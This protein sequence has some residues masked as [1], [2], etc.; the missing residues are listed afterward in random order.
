MATRPKKGPLRIVVMFLVPGLIGAAVG[1]A[2]VRYFPAL[3]PMMEFSG[4][5]KAALVAAVLLVVPLVIAVHEAGHLLGGRL[6]GFRALVLLVGPFRLERTGG[7]VR[8]ALNRNAALAGGLAVSVPEDTHDLRRRTMLMIAGGPGAS[9]LTGA[10]ALALRAPLGLAGSPPGA[11]FGHVLASVGLVVFGLVSLAIGLVTLIPR[12]SGGFYTDGARLLRLLRSGPDTDREVAIHTLMALSMGGRRP[13]EW[14]PQLVAQANSLA[15][16][17]PFEVVGRQVAAAWAMDRGDLDEARRH[18]DAA[19]ELE[20]V[21]SPVGRPALLL[22]AA[23]FAAAHDGD[24]ARARV[25]FERAGAGLMVPE[26]QRLL[27]EAA[28]C[29]AEGDAERAGA[30]LDGAEARLDRALDRGGA[31]ADLEMIRRLR[32]AAG[33]PRAS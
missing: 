25:L 20:E 24:A 12:N 32:A 14:D 1:A 31:L 3:L 10:A 18:L 16:A 26:H 28:M 7:G 2:A 27:V 22:Q 13:R 23:G 8:A 30:L 21:L 17:T 5:Q 6:A 29:L 15:D 33:A 4:A 11:G 19:L 9:L